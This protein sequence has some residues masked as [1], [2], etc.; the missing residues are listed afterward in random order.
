M[1]PVYISIYFSL[2]MKYSVSQFYKY[3]IILTVFCLR[4]CFLSFDHEMWNYFTCF[5]Q[6]MLLNVTLSL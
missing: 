3:S 1:L 4:S 2:T 6:H 5:Q